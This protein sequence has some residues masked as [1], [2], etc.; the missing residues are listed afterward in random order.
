[1]ITVCQ[2]EIKKASLLRD[3][4]NWCIENPQEGEKLAVDDPKIKAVPRK[5]LSHNIF[6]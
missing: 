2:T 5:N 1:M 4:I 6:S 3:M